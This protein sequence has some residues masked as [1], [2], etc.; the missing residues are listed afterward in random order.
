MLAALQLELERLDSRYKKLTRRVDSLRGS[1]DA[2]LILSLN[3]EAAIV[4]WSHAKLEVRIDREK[5]RQEQ[6]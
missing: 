1:D 4:A 5:A 3:Y 6:G 2:A